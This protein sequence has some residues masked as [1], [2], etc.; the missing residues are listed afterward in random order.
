MPQRKGMSLPN[1]TDQTVRFLKNTNIPPS[2]D[3]AIIL[4]SG[5]G[6]FTRQIEN[7]RFLSYVEI[8]GMPR[9]SVAGHEGKLIFGEINSRPVM[10]FSGRYHH[11]EGFSFEETAIPV[12]LAKALKA[13]KLIISNAS[14]AINTSFSV[15][16]LM[17]IEDVIRGN[18]QISPNGH[19]RHACRHHQ[20]TNAVRS[21][22][23]GINIPIRQGTYMYAKGPNY[24]TRAEIRAF[25][26]MGADAVGMSTA[27]ELFEAARLDLKTVAISLISNMAAGITPGKLNHD[28]VKAAAAS[29]KEAFATLVRELINKF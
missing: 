17:V 28:E 4:G 24:E 20:W 8:P 15:G 27:P 23:S 18:Q 16:D 25:R 1:F 21:L 6:G 13:K 26:R 5:L 14:G 12:Y 11:Y 22:A 7:A 29:R 10:A 3:T 19:Q 2:F 9:T